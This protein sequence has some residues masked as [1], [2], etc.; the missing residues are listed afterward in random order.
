MKPIKNRI[1]IMAVFAA[2][3]ALC[4]AALAAES[5]YM[6]IQGID[7][8]V[9]LK[10]REGQIEVFALNH[11]V[12]APF[13]AASGQ[14]TGKRVHNPVKVVTRISRATPLIAQAL[15]N[16]QVI[17]KIEVFFWNASPNGIEQNYFKI[18][19]ENCRV[20][21]RRLWDPNKLDPAT[22]NYIPL[23]ELA[24][25]Y[26]KITWTYTVGAIEYSDTWNAAAQ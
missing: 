19:I 12:A 25:V 1:V 20:S 26:Q 4:A 13:D 18:T 21:S 22:A 3:M 17:P 5:M 15:G 24:F 2:W 16:N 6:R 14:T 7:G 10:G 8:E 23:E 9:T 11:E